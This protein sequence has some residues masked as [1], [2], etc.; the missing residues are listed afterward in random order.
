ME[1]PVLFIEGTSG[2]IPKAIIKKLI[3]FGFDVKCVPDNLA[4]IATHRNEADIIL[5]YLPGSVSQM[6]QTMPYLF[7]LCHNE[8]KTLSVAGEPANISRAKV[9]DEDEI[10]YE[11]Y[12]RPI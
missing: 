4:E 7:E 12:P 8:H 10:I 5:Y 3:E 9:F 11:F 6:E 1:T 2:F